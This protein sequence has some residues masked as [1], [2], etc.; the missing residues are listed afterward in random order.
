MKYKFSPSL[1][2]ETRN[3]NVIFAVNFHNNLYYVSFRVLDSWKDNNV[4]WKLIFKS[5]VLQ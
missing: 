1:Q 5:N 4:S 3:Q 2:K